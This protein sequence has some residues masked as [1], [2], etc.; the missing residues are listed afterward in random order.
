MVAPFDPPVASVIFVDPGTTYHAYVHM[1]ALRS[2][3]LRVVAAWYVKHNRAWLWDK[4]LR[5]QP[6]KGRF[7]VET[8]R[9]EIYAGRGASQVLETKEK[10]G[11]IKEAAEM[12]GFDPLEITASEWR[13]ALMPEVVAMRP[14][15]PMD[16][17]IKFLVRRIFT[18]DDGSVSI[19]RVDSE[20]RDPDVHVY[21]AIGGGIVML[22]RLLGRPLAFPPAIRAE[23][24]KVAMV[25]R[26]ARRAHKTAKKLGVAIPRRRLSASAQAAANAKRKATVKAKRSG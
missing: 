8:I 11:R 15:P 6:L 25:A 9:G 10:E 19:P 5:L 23:L 13:E 17:V 1:E 21:D 16:E 18:E 26:E 7:V 12:R 14:K 2:G 20:S 4:L 3:R 24:L 22:S